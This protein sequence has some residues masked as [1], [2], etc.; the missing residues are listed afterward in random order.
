[1]CS[2]CSVDVGVQLTWT[3]AEPSRGGVPPHSGPVHLVFVVYLSQLHT[4]SSFLRLSHSLSALV[5]TS[6]IFI[7]LSSA[8]VCGPIRRDTEN[9]IL[10]R[11][12]DL[13]A[14]PRYVVLLCRCLCFV[15]RKPEVASL[16]STSPSLLTAQQ[17]GLLHARSS[18]LSY[19]Q[20]G[21]GLVSTTF[22]QST[23]EK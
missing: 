20:R 7:A 3:S 13:G 18:G 23:R 8:W 9:C 1:M 5:L 12:C 11:R 21:G 14:I 10:C 19:T 17:C 6:R 16:S 22:R 2:A 4:V 15:V